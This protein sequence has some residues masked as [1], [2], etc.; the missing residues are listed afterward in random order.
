MIN[1][2]FQYVWSLFIEGFQFKLRPLQARLLI[3]KAMVSCISCTPN[4]WPETYAKKCRLY[5]S[6]YGYIT[7]FVFQCPGS[8]FKSVTVF[9]THLKAQRSSCFRGVW[10]LE[11]FFTRRV[12]GLCTPWSSILKP[13]KHLYFSFYF[14]SHSSNFSVLGIT[15][16]VCRFCSQCAMITCSLQVHDFKKKKLAF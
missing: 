16:E 9:K 10:R 3:V 11:K 14:K 1:N 2:R 15:F 12:W 4:F 6:L 13:P 7:I 5:T 8:C